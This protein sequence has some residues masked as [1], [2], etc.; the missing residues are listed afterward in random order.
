MDKQY[1]L[2][3]THPANDWNEALPLGNGRLGVMAYG[4][5]ERELLQINEETLW[6]G[7]HIDRNN[8]FTLENLPKIREL[9][10]EGKIQE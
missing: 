8:P 2:W 6:S 5:P 10:L 7:L 1:K 3:Y 4:R 9:V